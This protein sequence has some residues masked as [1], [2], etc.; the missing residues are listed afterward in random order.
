MKSG[1]EHDAS[2]AYRQNK[3]VPIIEGVSVNLDSYY[4]SG[5]IDVQ[6]FNQ[7]GFA[8]KNDGA[9]SSAMDLDWSYDGKTAHGKDLYV[10]PSAETV[11]RAGHTDIKAPYMRVIVKNRDKLAP[12]VMSA[13]AYLK[14]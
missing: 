1:I 8:I 6:G 2:L 9:T 7:V 3:T 4:E 11:L 5:W 12:H 10:I 13:Y 14:V